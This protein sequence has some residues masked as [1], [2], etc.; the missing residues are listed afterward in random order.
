[1]SPKLFSAALL[2]LLATPADAA[3]LLANATYGQGDGSSFVL[4]FRPRLTET[5]ITT[6]NL[7]TLTAPVDGKMVDLPGEVIWGNGIAVPSGFVF[8]ECAADEPDCSSYW[9]GVIY[10]VEGDRAFELPDEDAAA[11]KGILL[12]DLGRSLHYS[13]LVMDALPADFFQLKGCK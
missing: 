12:S 5:P 9:D 4:Q 2:S 7:F 6:S 8:A 11:P 13:G 3:C 1:M 10:A